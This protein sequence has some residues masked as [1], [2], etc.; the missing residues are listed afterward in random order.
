MNANDLFKLPRLYVD[1]PLAQDQ[2]LALPDSQAHYLGTVLRRTAGDRV[3]LFNGRDGEFLAVLEMPSRKNIVAKPVQLLKPQ[4]TAKTQTHLLFAPLKKDALD[5]LIEKAVELGATH[6][7]PVLTQNTEVRRL[8]EERVRQQIIESAEQTERMDI[9]QLAAPTELITLL[10]SWNTEIKI[11]AGVERDKSID[12]LPHK[13]SDNA[14]F[15]IGP[16]GGFT[17]QEKSALASRDFVVPV[18][19]GDTILRAET[20]ALFCLSARRLTDQIS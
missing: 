3:R 10:E 1:Q 9:P 16:E 20:A 15:L 4:P 14:A 2:A 17:A 18:T 13:Y 7:H 6:L 12:S 11:H 5:F 19:L 8:N